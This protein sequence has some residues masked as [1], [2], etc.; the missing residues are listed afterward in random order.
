MQDRVDFLLFMHYDRS[1]SNFH[2][3]HLTIPDLLLILVKSV[4]ISVSL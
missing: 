3:K 1:F 2:L 4:E